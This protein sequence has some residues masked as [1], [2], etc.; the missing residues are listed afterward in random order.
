MSEAR[1]Y[2]FDIDMDMLREGVREYLDFDPEIEDPEALVA[3]IANIV[4]LRAE[5]QIRLA[6]KVDKSFKR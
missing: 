1:K 2:L 5:Q 4:R 3:R 6:L